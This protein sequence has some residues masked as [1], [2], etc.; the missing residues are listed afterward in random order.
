M[1]PDAVVARL[2]LPPC[3]WQFPQ[4]ELADDSGLVVV[5]GDLSP[6]TLVTAYASGLFPMPVGRRRRLGWW[7]P[8]PR[9]ILPVDG[10]KVSRSLRRSLRR[11]EVRVDTVF[12]DTMARCGDPRRPHGW[13]TPEFVDAYSAMNV[14]GLAHSVECWEVG[15]LVGGLYGISIGGLFAGESMF[16]IAPDA[17]KVALVALI[18]LLRTHDVPLLDVQWLTPHLASLGAVEIRRDAYLSEMRQAIV[19]PQP[20]FTPGPT[21]PR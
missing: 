12:S 13:I 9:G 15:Q 11:Y 6:S 18:E 20:K 21:T 2:G 3:P 16:H 4:P 17:S 19:Q 5:G 14:L 8:D 1:T 7:S 10:L